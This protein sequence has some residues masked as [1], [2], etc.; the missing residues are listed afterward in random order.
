MIFILRVHGSQAGEL[1]RI[2]FAAKAH[3]GY[4]ERWMELWRPQL[5]F[6]A[7]YF[8]QYE[9][10]AAIDGTEPVAFYTLQ[11]KNGH[12]WLENLWVLPAYMGQGVGAALFRHAVDLAR[13]RGYKKLQLEADPN[14]TG[15]YRKMGMQQIGER[16][17][18][19]EGQWRILPI[20]ELEM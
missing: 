18:A 2:A 5:T 16:R 20:M 13:Q 19:L 10:W 6:G 4:P 14:A 9:S 1:S 11:E 15:F 12:A 7:D 17:Y 8:E 3:W